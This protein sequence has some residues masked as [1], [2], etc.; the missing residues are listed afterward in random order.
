[1]TTASKFPEEAFKFLTWISGKEMNVQG[2]VQG[3]KGP[4]ARP[5]VL[6]DARITDKWPTYKKIKTIMDSI[7]AD[8]PVANFRGEEFDSAGSWSRLERGEIP[9]LEMANEIQRLAQEVLNKE[10]A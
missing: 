8:Y 2:L 9:V 3:A 10:P 5:D 1:V 4:I 6:S 7:E